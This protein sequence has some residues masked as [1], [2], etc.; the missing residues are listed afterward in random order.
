MANA[1]STKRQT[2]VHNIYI[3]IQYTK[4]CATLSYNKMVDELQRLRRVLS[5]CSTSS[6]CRVPLKRHEYDNTLFLLQIALKWI[7][8]Y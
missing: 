1:K 3:Y 2:M 8:T 6:S 5:S 7:T 4:D